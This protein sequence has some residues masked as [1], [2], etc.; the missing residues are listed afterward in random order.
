MRQVVLTG[1]AAWF[2]AEAAIIGGLASFRHTVRFASRPIRGVPPADQRACI[3]RLVRAVEAAAWRLPFRSVCLQKGVAF[4][5]MCRRRGIDAQL[6]YGVAD[7]GQAIAAHVWVSVDGQ[8][9]LGGETADTF[10]QV[11]TW[12]T[13]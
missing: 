9:Y 1:E 7:D 2:L 11:A 10:A 4:Q 12:P 6:H 3:Q 5:R 13:R 8:I